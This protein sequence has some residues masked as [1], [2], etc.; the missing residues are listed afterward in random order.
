M[1]GKQT[2]NHGLR[3]KTSFFSLE[4]LDLNET[5]WKGKKWHEVLGCVKFNVMEK[6]KIKQRLV[7]LKKVLFQKC[8][9]ALTEPGWEYFGNQDSRGPFSI[10]NE[11]CRWALGMPSPASSP[12]DSL[13]QKNTL[14]RRKRREALVHVKLD[15]KSGPGSVLDTLNEHTLFG[16]L[17]F[18]IL[19]L[20]LK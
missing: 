20:A 9:V 6:R 3:D 17:I 12:S 19:S 15:V 4:R 8:S 1:C 5:P 10:L 13:T 11:I 18:H 16:V 7:P 2:H 14:G